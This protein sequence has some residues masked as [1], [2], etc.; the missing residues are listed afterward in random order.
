MDLMG[1]TPIDALVRFYSR[2]GV[3]G[4]LWHKHSEYRIRLQFFSHNGRIRCNVEIYSDN[5]LR[6]VECWKLPRMF[7]KKNW[8]RWE[9]Y[10]FV[11]PKV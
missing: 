2:E 5:T 9:D 1:E 6:K 4:T 10:C 3:G 8:E 7:S 11:V